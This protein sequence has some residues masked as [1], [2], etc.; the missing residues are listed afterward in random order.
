MEV[1]GW[2]KRELRCIDPTYYVRVNTV[3][4]SYDVMKD[5]EI[6]LKFKDGTVY[7]RKEP[8]VV[9]S[10]PYA[11]SEALTNLRYRKWLGR[12]MK[13]VEHPERE[14]KMLQEAEDEHKRKEQD[15]GTEL[16]AQGLIEHDNLANKRRQSWSYGG[17]DR[18]EA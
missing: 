12:Q 13:I 15:A 16:V 18:K 1:P 6:Y 7:Q 5:A 4:Q 2:F 10:Y 3:A 17:S 14:R 8:R 9:G 11:N